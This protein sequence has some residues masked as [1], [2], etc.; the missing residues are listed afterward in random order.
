M[1]AALCEQIHAQLLERP[2]FKFVLVS[3]LPRTEFDVVL[4]FLASQQSVGELDLSS[5][6]E[7]SVKLYVG[8]CTDVYKG[9][10][11]TCCWRFV[12]GASV[13]EC[14]GRV[15]VCHCSC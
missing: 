13:A 1:I 11:A 10:A 9:L 12:F 14:F 8:V 7:H 5:L 3:R 6:I 15:S 2:V 4:W